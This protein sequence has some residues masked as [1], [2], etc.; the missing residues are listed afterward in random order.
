MMTESSIGYQEC[1][2]YQ[3]LETK[4]DKPIHTPALIESDQYDFQRRV[5]WAPTTI[6]KNINIYSLMVKHMWCEQNEK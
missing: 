1:N 5:W 2:M 3:I 6:T 4:E